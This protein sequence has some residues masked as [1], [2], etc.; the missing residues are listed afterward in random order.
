MYFSLVLSTENFCFQ[1]VIRVLLG[2]QIP[3]PPFNLNLARLLTTIGELD[4]ILV[5]ELEMKELGP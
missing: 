1:T 2:D 5:L 3:L 4:D